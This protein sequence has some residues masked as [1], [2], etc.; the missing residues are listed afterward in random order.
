M[1]TIIAAFVLALCITGCNQK[2]QSLE[3]IWSGKSGQGS[4]TFK[5]QSFSIQRA[6][7]P[8][9]RVQV[10]GTFTLKENKL[11]FQPQSVTPLKGTSPLSDTDKKTVTDEVNKLNPT[12]VNWV[13]EDAIEFKD[14]SGKSFTYDKII[15]DST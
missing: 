7:P 8:V 9:G 14:P 1:K 11:T 5:G 10:D 2:N 3:G 4:I 15:T 6:F 12:T 13:S